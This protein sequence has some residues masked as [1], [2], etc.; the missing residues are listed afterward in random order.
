M[1]IGPNTIVAIDYVLTNDAGEE[2]DS[3]KGAEPLAYLHGVGQLI[4]DLEAKLEGL[5]EG[6]N[7]KATFPPEE[8]YGLHREELLQD[9]PRDRFPE[10]MELEVGVTLQ[11]QGP[12]GVQLVN[13][14]SVDDE[15]VGLDGNHPLAG[16]TLHFDV[17]VKG[18]RE[19]TPEEIA[20]SQGHGDSCGSGCTC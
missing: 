17:T 6:D 8:G 16:S 11:V 10:S 13:V 9:V 2:I 4:P 1:K 18:V 7:V 12:A 15:N 3:S 20:A 5:V 19:A 14:V